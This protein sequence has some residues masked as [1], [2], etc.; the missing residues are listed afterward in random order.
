MSNAYPSHPNAHAGYSLIEMMIAMVLGLILVAG[1]FTI[2]S[3]N[4]QSQAN[5]QL[6]GRL[7]ENGRYV[8]DIIS[9]DIRRAGYFSG[10]VKVD[11]VGGSAGIS[12]SQA[13]CS[14]TNSTW[15]RMIG[16]PIFGL[17]DTNVGYDC[18]ADADY[19]RGDVLTVRYANSAE[20]ATFSANRP[21]IRASLFGGRL[22]EGT[23]EPLNSL[24]VFPQ[25]TRAIVAHTYFVGPTADT[26]RD[27]NSIPGLFWKTIGDDGLPTTELLVAGIDNFQIQYGIDTTGDTSVNQYHNAD[28]ISSNAALE[29]N[30]VVAIKVWVLAGTGC[31]D[32]PVLKTANFAIGGETYTTSDLAIRQLYSTT[33]SLRN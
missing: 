25:S 27:G 4:I 6:L 17:N 29:F 7:Q 11:L 18:I 23:D 24:T 3:T 30:Q 31:A 26:C 5:Q 28:T 10:N 19:L 13:S 16:Q 8:L 12:M 33:I 9:R 15:S 20:A 1:M 2:Y 21:Y 14:D 22:F 32:I